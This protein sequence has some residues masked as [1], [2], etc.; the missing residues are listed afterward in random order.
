MIKQVILLLSI[1]NISCNSTKEVIEKATI[2]SDCPRDGKCNVELFQNKSL[3]I[4]SDPIGSF[5]YELLDNSKTTV[6]KYEYIKT[7][8]T[9]LQDNNYKEELLFEI[10]NEFREINLENKELESVK[11]L[12][13]K[14]C[15]CRGQAGIYKVKNGKLIVTKTNSNIIFETDFDIPN[16]DQKI[17]TIKTII[18]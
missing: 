14:H 13:G 5:Y 18:K 6:V 8:D 17:K 11:M 12:Y 7:V 3:N 15:F 10:P 2:L 9:L 1:L 16:I 4:K